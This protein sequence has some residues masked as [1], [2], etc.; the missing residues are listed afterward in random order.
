M[1]KIPVTERQVP[2][3]GRM[4]WYCGTEHNLPGIPAD[5]TEMPAVVTHV[6]AVG[7][8]WSAVDL[9]VFRRDDVIH[10]AAVEPCRLVDASGPE[11][12]RY[13]WPEFFPPVTVS[14]GGR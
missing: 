7:N 13:R 1:P 5:L 2:T 14:V 10:R 4:V 3:I 9:T 12:Y 6:Y 11:P 8:P